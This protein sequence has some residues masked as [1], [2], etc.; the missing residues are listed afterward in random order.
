MEKFAQTRSQKRDELHAL[1]ETLDRLE[2]LLEDMN[3][4]SISSRLEAETRMNEIHARLDELD[5]TI[6]PLT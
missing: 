6:P 5:Q 2:E 4:L 1:L 3:D